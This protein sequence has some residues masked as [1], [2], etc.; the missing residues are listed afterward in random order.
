MNPLIIAFINIIVL[1]G[2][3]S[4]YFKVWSGVNWW[5]DE[6]KKQQSSLSSFMHHLEP[7]QYVYAILTQNLCYYHLL[8]PFKN[9]LGRV[10]IYNHIIWCHPDY[11]GF[12]FGPGFSQGFFLLSP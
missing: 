3:L 2:C 4:V 8:M 5:M 9:S 1:F 10:M 7:Q 6:W 12:P 11:D